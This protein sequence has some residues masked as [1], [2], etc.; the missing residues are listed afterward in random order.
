VT[1]PAQGPPPAS[2]EIEQAPRIGPTWQADSYHVGPSRSASGKPGSA[3]KIVMVST[4]V[5]FAVALAIGGV[6]LTSSSKSAS[7]K[8][9]SH[10]ISLT[11]SNKPSSS[12]AQNPPMIP[13]PP[14]S[15]SALHLVGGPVASDGRLLVINVTASRSLQLSAI[16]PATETVVWQRPYS[17]SGITPGEPFPPSVFGDIAI[18]FSPTPDTTSVTGQILG[19][20][21]ANG[22]VAWTHSGTGVAGDAPVA[23]GGPNTFCLS[24]VS[25]ITQSLIE[26]NATNGSLLR[27]IP[28]VERDLGT[29][30]YQGDQTNPTLIQIGRQGQMLWQSPASSVF[31]TVND[32]PDSGWDVDPLGLLDVGSLGPV[33]VPQTSIDFNS[34]TTTGFAIATGRPVWT[35]A[36]LYNCSG[37]LEIFSTP[38]LCRLHGTATRT[39][40]GGV[41]T[42]GVTLTL[43]GF[44]TQTGKVTWSRPDQNLIG[45]IGTGG[46]P[47]ED[48]DHI[49]IKQRGTDLILD[50]AT[51]E[52]RPV[53]SGQVFW[54]ATTPTVQVIAPTGSGFPNERSATDQFF[55]CNAA[56]A[57]VSTHPT[58]QPTLVGVVLGGKFFWPTPHGLQVATAT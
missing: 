43:E 22:A 39:T 15:M 24:W 8:P 23:C 26:V 50:L 27:T 33:V 21:I 35:D 17:A 18:D 34:A 54:C 3:R 32:N 14:I 31:G 13:N 49:V 42:A 12:T 48:G 40:S 9:I 20:D 45:L 41:S 5:V 29:N 37:S 53:S 28:N 7:P 55:G 25:D 19:I 56:G 10:P 46:L 52:V 1:S 11:K 2:P 6:A 58:G 36:G 16:D 30:L 4:A 38:T 51:G 44:N 57:A 47:F